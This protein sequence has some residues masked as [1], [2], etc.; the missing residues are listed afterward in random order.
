MTTELVE[1][2]K[3]NALIEAERIANEEAEKKRQSNLAHK[4]KI[5]G[6]ILEGFK[7]SGIEANTAKQVLKA[8]CEEKIPHV[9][10]IY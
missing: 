3:V 7:S 4:K 10:V 2:Q 6:E 1:I 9:K 5:Q 8:L